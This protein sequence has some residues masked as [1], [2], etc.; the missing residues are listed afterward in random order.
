MQMFKVHNGHVVAVE[1]AR[2]SEDSVWE[3]MLNGAETRKMR[4]PKTDKQPAYYA[5]AEEAKAALL[6]AAQQ[7]VDVAMK[8]L[9][10]AKA[11]Y[12]QI[13]EM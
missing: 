13:A 5:T 6:T 4:V 11:R 2:V 1:V 9:E 10:S 3:V 7:G 8:R 12:Q